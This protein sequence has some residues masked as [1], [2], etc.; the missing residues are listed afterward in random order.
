MLA[1]VASLPT[2]GLARPKCRVI[3]GPSRDSHPRLRY[4]LHNIINRTR[5]M[6]RLRV[7]L[8]RGA[9]RKHRAR[10]SEPMVIVKLY[11][12][13]EYS[14]NA[15]ILG[16]CIPETAGTHDGAVCCRHNGRARRHGRAAATRRRN[17][18][19]TFAVGGAA[20][21]D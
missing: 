7:T 17:G 10:A 8:S 4:Y 5:P 1:R 3:N 20:I 13:K 9:T 18:R 15:C 16:R 2:A 6:K 19:A 12:N 14:A 11:Y 21:I